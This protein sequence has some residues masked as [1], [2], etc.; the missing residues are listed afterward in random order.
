[1][2]K[3][4]AEKD[5]I[6]AELAQLVASRE[7]AQIAL[8]ETVQEFL[9]QQSMPSTPRCSSSQGNVPKLEEQIDYWQERLQNQA[10]EAVDRLRGGESQL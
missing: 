7:A 9:Q 4:L 1:M 10:D 6:I 5:A 2:E 8:V 3:Q